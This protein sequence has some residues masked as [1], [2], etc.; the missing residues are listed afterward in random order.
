[1]SPRTFVRHPGSTAAGVA[2]ALSL[3]VATASAQITWSPLSPATS[4]PVRQSHSM[5]FDSTRGRVVVFGGFDGMG[6]Y[7]NDTWEWDGTNW[8]QMTPATS[9]SARSGAAME[10]DAAT[11]RTV[12]FGGADGAGLMA[13]TWDWDGT[14]WTPHAP[15][16]SPSAR[17]SHAM[18]YD[19]ARQQILL[20]G[21]GDGTNV[22]SDTWAWNGSNWLSL[23]PATTPMARGGHAMAYDSV[24]DRVVLVG[25]VGVC[26]F[27]CPYSH[28]TWEWDGTDWSQLS[29]VNTPFA[30]DQFGIAYDSRRGQTVIFGGNFCASFGCFSRDDTWSWDGTDWTQLSPARMPTLRSGHRM[31]Y[32]SAHNE[33]VL[34][35]GLDN[36]GT[37]ND[38]W[39]ISEPVRL[40]S[41]A[42]AD[43]SENGGD[44]VSIYGTSFT[45]RAD[46]TVTIGGANAVVLLVEPGRTLVRTPAGSGVADVTLTNSTGVSSLRGAFTYVAP[47]IAA[48]FGAVNVGLGDRENPLLING[49]TGDVNRVVTVRVGDPIGAFVNSPSTTPSARFC[50]YAWLGSPNA[51]TRTMLPH[52]LGSMVFPTPFAGTT[53]QPR[54]LFNN[55]GH[56]AILG[57]RT[58]PSSPAPSVLF[59]RPGGLARSLTAAFQG[60]IEDPGSMIPEGVS[61][62]NAVVLRITP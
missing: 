59:N 36:S 10:F 41:V 56:T 26:T 27:T 15:A 33:T 29:P 3:F 49:N 23:S 32:D 8:M 5:A 52:R 13:D 34:F 16:S 21:G 18:A 45:N 57:V 7:L 46:T 9:P 37:Q 4:P 24:R 31:V 58:A 44:A 50:V 51:A 35:G 28:E 48:R 1:M 55:L 25:G 38:T 14:T 39:V 62:T 6:G 53:P 2:A 11:G 42:P 61:V 17:A 20:F 54:T 43:G 19:S 47:E 40:T 22:L 30:R 12:L 60:L